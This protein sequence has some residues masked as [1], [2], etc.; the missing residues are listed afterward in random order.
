MKRG[1][2]V[3]DTQCDKCTWRIHH[4]QNVLSFS[5]NKR[6]TACSS[7]LSICSMGGMM[8]CGV[9][10]CDVCVLVLSFMAGIRVSIVTTALSER[11]AG[12]VMPEGQRQQRENG[13]PDK[14][15]TCRIAGDN[16]AVVR[17]LYWATLFENARDATRTPK[18]TGENT[19]TTG[20]YFTDRQC[21]GG[22]G[23]G[24]SSQAFLLFVPTAS[25]DASERLMIQ[26]TF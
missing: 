9:T 14:A 22:G 26:H 15:S 17:P 3:K 6:N 7:A 21:H 18:N 12:R 1:R 16:T 25:G 8:R 23:V 2:G 4:R 13:G 11:R 19:K 5:N 10:Q 24:P 20:A